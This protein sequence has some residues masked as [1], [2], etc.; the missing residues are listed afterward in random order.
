MKYGILNEISSHEND[1]NINIKQKNK[2]INNFLPEYFNSPLIGHWEITRACNL[3]CVHCYNNSC[4]SLRNELSHNEKINIANQIV[5]EKIFRFCISGGEPILCKSLWD[6]AKI[7]K[8]GKVYCNTITNGWFVNEDNVINYTR[9]FNNIQVSIDG[10]TPE[11]HDKIRGKKGSWKKAINA[12]KLIVENKGSLINATSIMSYNYKELDK[13]ID[14]SYNLGSKKIVID[15]LHLVGRA[16]K[17][18]NNLKITNN[19]FNKLLK[20][21]TRKKQ[22]YNDKEFIINF[23]P[24]KFGYYNNFSF[25][26]NLP[27]YISPSGTCAPHPFIPFTG[28]SLK[29]YTLKEVWN[30]IKKSYK[31]IEFIKLYRYLTRRENFIKLKNIP[32][33]NCELHDK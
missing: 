13:I 23:V 31:N 33:V 17:N 22:E 3:K 27:F 24:K 6:I 28:K 15:Y 7:L 26:S 5:K 21:I 19:H 18:Y 25:S 11:T 29:M 1:F 2:K 30:D 4:N 16:A 20:T 14:L 32:Y 9:Y 12:S 8:E 10:S